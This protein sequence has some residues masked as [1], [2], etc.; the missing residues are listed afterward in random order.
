MIVQKIVKIKETTPLILPT[1]IVNNC[2]SDTDV[3][4]YGTMDNNKKEDKNVLLKTSNV[5]IV[6]SKEYSVPNAKALDE[7]L[8]SNAISRSN[9]FIHPHQS[10]NNNHKDEPKP[11]SIGCFLEGKGSSCWSSSKSWRSSVDAIVSWPIRTVLH[12]TVPDCH[13][14]EWRRWYGLT[15]A[16]CVAWIAVLTYMVTWMIA[17]IGETFSIPDSVTGLTFLAAGTSIPEVISSVIVARQGLGCMGFS[18]TVGS[19]TFDLLICLGLPWLIKSSFVSLGYIEIHSGGLE[20][21]AVILVSSVAI[22][23]AA[24]ALNGFVLDRKVGIGCILMYIVFITFACMLEMNVFFPVNLP[25]C[26]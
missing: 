6:I 11:D 20:Y 7:M 10:S 22:L 15:L 2:P 5:D 21:S 24:I 13:T 19:N 14:E 8:I 26:D 1:V 18:N 4:T 17:I 25:P 23:Y 3:K 12:L 16:M 9:S